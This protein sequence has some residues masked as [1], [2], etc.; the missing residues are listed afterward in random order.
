MASQ[1]QYRKMAAASKNEMAAI[2]AAGGEE[3]LNG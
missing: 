3:S 2:M 1:R